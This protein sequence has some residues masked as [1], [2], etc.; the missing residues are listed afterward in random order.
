M[1]FFQQASQGPS[2]DFSHVARLHA[3]MC[4]QRLKKDHAPLETPDDKYNYAVS[5]LNQK[6]NLEDA[7]K[8]LRAA[9]EAKYSADHF[10]YALA[11]CLGL[12]GDYAGSSQHLARAIALAPNNRT[13]ARNDPDFREILQSPAMRAL[14]AVKPA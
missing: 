5:L 6:A 8:H 13:I 3:K 7:E 14:L 11:L 12:R 4:E 1:K 9:V 10:H 2:I